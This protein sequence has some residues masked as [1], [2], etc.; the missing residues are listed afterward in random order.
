M[1]SERSTDSSL[2]RARRFT[3]RRARVGFRRARHS[4]IP[5]LQMTVAGV[6][7]YTV[8]EQLLGHEAPLFAAIAALI[9]LGFSKEP[10]MRK[11]LEVS[12]GCTLGILIGDVLLQLLGSNL[13]TAAL[14]LFLSIMLARFLDPGPV[15]AMQM[16]LQALLVVLIPPPEVG[17][18]GPFTRSADAIV[19]GA[20]ALLITLLTPKDPRREPIAE[21]KSVV[22]AMTASLRDV[23][24]AV[25]SSDSRQAW[26][27]LIRCRGLQ[28]Q[29][30]ELRTA[31]N[32]AKELTSF[33]PAYRKHRHYVRHMAEVAD[34]V[35]LAV[36]SMRVVAR[37][38]ISTVDNASLTDAGVE[39]L[40]AVLD[41]FADASLLLSQAVS[42]PGPAYAQRM[43]TAQDAL[44]SLAQHLHPKSLGI[45]TLEG[46]T[47]VLLL[48]T[49]VVD[50]LQAAGSTHADARDQLP[51]L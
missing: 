3:R 11:V 19:G 41:E 17:L 29:I 47:V 28:P 46:E 27:S 31:V 4:V 48:R 16:G 50:L 35:D 6:G 13:A 7:A 32:S 43:E 39:N 20:V 15:L 44:A 9:A 18:L 33:S 49:L 5:A 26:H 2:A 51:E 38:I 25:R 24:E 10:R 12:V 22:D 30:D 40:S 1:T 42:E 36:R 8:A 21:L 23:A 14:V 34:Q 45:V 37:R